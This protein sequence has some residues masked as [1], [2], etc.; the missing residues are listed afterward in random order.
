M[1][2]RF[3]R[4]P[5]GAYVETDTTAPFGSGPIYKG[6]IDANDDTLEPSGLTA[7]KSKATPVIVREFPVHLYPPKSW[8][9]LDK[10][11]YVALPT[12][13][14]QAVVVSYQVPLGRSAVIN[15]VANN[16]VGG[17]WVEGSGAVTWQILV[18][19]TPP[20]GAH[21]YSLIL[22]SL[23]SPANPV[24]IAGFRVFENQVLTLVVNNVSVALAGQLSGG[25]L[26]G[27]VYPRDL[28]EADT[29]L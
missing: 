22:A 5:L 24:G 11:S 4:R 21:D 6:L 3:R 2:G 19:G 25:R 1:S 10:C 8:E 18:D 17:G 9:N 15:K 29:W 14:S 23:G 27:Y 13:G 12:I 20:P 28:E 16:F 26:I 7:A